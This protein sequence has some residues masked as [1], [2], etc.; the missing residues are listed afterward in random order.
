MRCVVWLSGWLSFDLS[1]LI[2][3]ESA[4]YLGGIVNVDTKVWDTCVLV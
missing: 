1:V 2:V 4:G 3:N